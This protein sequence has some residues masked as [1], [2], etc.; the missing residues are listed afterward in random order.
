MS[1]EEDEKLGA[2]AGLAPAILAALTDGV[3]VQDAGGQL[4]YANE[5][6]ARLLGFDSAAE[7]IA[8]PAGE[9]FARL[10]VLDE[11]RRPF[12]FAELPNRIALSEDSEAT[13]TACF[14]I[15]ETGEERWSAIRSLS[16]AADD[17][18]VV[19]VNLI[20]D[21]TE[22]RR[23]SEQLRLLADASELLVSSL[24]TEIT[25]EAITNMLVP[26]F[27]DYCLIDLVQ[28]DGGMVGAA[29]RHNDPDREQVLRQIRD[30]YPPSLNPE[31]PVSIV[32]STG[33][34]LLIA[35]ADEPELER[36]ALDAEHLELYRQ[37]DASSYLVVPL[38]ARGRT[39][40]TLSLGM[41]E[42]R[43]HYRDA[44][45]VFAQEVAGR[46]ALGVDNTRLYADASESLALLDTLLISSPVAIGYWDPELRFV[47]VNDA[48]ASING[49]STADHVGRTIA[50]VIPGLAPT[51]E[52]LY[53]RV[54]ATGEPVVHEES[55]D[56]EI[57]GPGSARHWLSSYYPV[58]TE[59]GETIGVGGVIMEI[60]GQRRA[61]ARLRLLAEAGELFATSLE[62][63]DVLEKIQRVV[64]PR[65]ADSFH[66]FLADGAV[67]RRAACSHVDPELQGA[68]ESMPDTYELGPDSPAFMASVF[69]RGEPVLVSEVEH[70]FYEHLV[71]LGADRDALER[72]GSRSMMLVPLVARGAPLGVMA[73]GARRPG[74]YAEAD[75][76]LATELAGRAAAAIDNARLVRELTYRSTVLEA[77]QEAS[78]DGL[79]LVSSEGA[80]VSY[81]RR[82][83]EVWGFSDALVSAGSDEAA[84][85]EA[86]TKVADPDAFIARVQ[87]LYEHPER[88]SRDEIVL[89]DGRVLDRYGSPVRDPA[90]SYFGWLW[91]FRDVTEQE[92]AES[93]VNFLAEASSLFASSL[94][95][96]A[97]L[98]SLAHLAVPRLAD[99]CSITMLEP[100]GDLRMLAAVHTD[101][102]KTGWAEELGR[103]FPPDPE[104]TS[105]IA[106]VIRSG[107]PELAHELS[108]EM[109]RLGTAGRPGYFEILRE[110]GLRSALIVPLRAR[111]K[112][113]GALTLI[114]AESGRLYD[115]SDL[116]LAQEVARRAAIAVDNALLY[117]SLEQSDRR[118]R[119]ALDSALLGSWE[120]DLR[121]H[122]V[123]RS[124]LHDLILGYGGPAGEWTYERFV[125][126]L[127]H[128]GDREGFE[129]SVQ[130]AVDS[131]GDLDVE[132]RITRADGIETWIWVRGAVELDA[133]G[134]PASLVGLIRDI[135]DVKAAEAELER[136][137]QAAQALEFVGEGVFLLDGSNVVRL[138][139]PAAEAITGLREE[140]VL[141][142]PLIES[143][144]AWA[145]VA[146][147]API[148]DTR[149]GGHVR[150]ETVPID[151]NGRELWISISGVA[152]GAGTVYAFRDLT[153]ERAVERLKSDFV[154][155]VSHELRTPLAA[156]YG[157]AMTL[158]RT[159][160]QLSDE[161]RDGMLGVV[162]DESERLARIVND[163]LVASR[164]DSGAADVSIGRA[165]AAEIVRTV[166]AAASVR[167]PEEIEL[168]VVLPADGPP[169][170]ADTDKV[171]QVLVNL[172]ENAIKYSPDGGEIRIELQPVEG[173]MRFSVSDPGLGIPASELGRIFEK[174][175]RLDPNLTRGV[176]GT[177]L[178]L[179]ICREI[180]RRLDGRIWVESEP[181]VGSTFSFDLPLA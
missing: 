145:A 149:Q 20:R 116:E 45:I 100:D 110:L 109:L 32:L 16:I 3:T 76:T 41:G 50:E 84:L 75:L 44:D 2:A 80:M 9:L 51:L 38:L 19:A 55:T 21:V 161:Q 82:F 103:R 177:G 128:P 88:T 164:L 168:S 162:A 23:A 74:R 157:A 129:R 124:L 105:G 158:K 154:S 96:E 178:G 121:T 15:R 156:I 108:E 133:S 89:K 83:A 25:I 47:R 138:W 163:I 170:F 39:I 99:W 49:I 18:R 12:P 155:T 102:E 174:F 28:A 101:P 66:L 92:R 98:A 52:P 8:A 131:R 77:Q 106:Q 91:S 46:I 68:V 123:T 11:Q 95:Y 119:F 65:L 5:T 59:G 85:A 126:E 69:E 13:R 42:S 181:G 93:A 30:R 54:L 31:H 165:D 127:L 73:I 27:A 40:G 147:V 153:D 107:E 17:G 130:E 78:L 90:G 166:V 29:L 136:R 61:D 144:P 81:N 140:D 148:T 180:V 70:E 150:A 63:E 120:L 160:V 35:I 115:E 179:Y 24:D 169:I 125:E 57:T 62:L 112:T 159:D 113:L 72:V 43:R 26:G 87:Y 79:L 104:A 139:N 33:A 152:F 117:L 34:P 135:G 134:E 10:E 56:E 132:C 137:A 141:G 111:G 86:M 167:L 37:L 60:T 94:D 118:R 36:A 14:R 114:T 67:L 122:Q 97:T 53:R 4:V 58:R 176:G 64:L 173:R 22:Q 172:I 151:V 71:R 146:A 1:V 48:L 6:A 175:Y 171:R 7:L 143:L 142:R